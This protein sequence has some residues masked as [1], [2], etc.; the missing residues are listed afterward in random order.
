MLKHSNHDDD[1]TIWIGPTSIRIGDQRYIRDDIHQAGLEIAAKHIDTEGQH[2][3]GT[4]VKALSI[5]E[6]RY[7][8][9][10]I[11]RDDIKRYTN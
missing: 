6:S 2:H 1:D 9:R 7:S 11:T 8:N 5:D 4:A 10:E 3:F